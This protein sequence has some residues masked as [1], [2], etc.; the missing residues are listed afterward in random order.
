MLEL[1]HVKLYY[2]LYTILLYYA[3]CNPKGGMTFC[4]YAHSMYDK[5]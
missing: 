5:N 4:A 1:D 3:V 2:Y